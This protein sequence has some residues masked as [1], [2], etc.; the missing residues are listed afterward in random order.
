MIEELGVQA[1][2]NIFSHLIFIYITWQVIQAVRLDGIFKKDRIIEGRILVILITI[3]IGST[4]SRFFIDL[5]NWA[6]QVLYLF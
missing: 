6:Q 5:I 3:V 4:V 1:L 2:I